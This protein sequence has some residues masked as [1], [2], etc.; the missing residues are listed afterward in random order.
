MAVLVIFMS[1]LVRQPVPPKKS[2]SPSTNGCATA[3]AGRCGA[4]TP[5]RATIARF[6]ASATCCTVAASS[7]MTC[8]RPAGVSTQSRQRGGGPLD[9]KLDQSSAIPTKATTPPMSDMRGSS[10]TAA[11]TAMIIPKAA[12][13]ALMTMS[14]T[15]PTPP[16]DAAASISTDVTCAIAYV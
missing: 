12:M 1:V 7:V 15:S 5:K 16:D 10:A 14:T 8:D 2:S 9:E 4:A 13:P 6:T 11:P 3:V